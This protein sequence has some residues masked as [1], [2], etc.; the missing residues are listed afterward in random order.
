VPEKKGRSVRG[1]RGGEG[2]GAR[3][4]QWSKKADG[5]ALAIPRKERSAEGDK[6]SFIGKNARGGTKKKKSAE[7]S[8]TLLGGRMHMS[9]F[10]LGVMFMC[11]KR[12][13]ETQNVKKEAGV[14][15]KNLRKHNS[16][17]RIK[18]TRKKE[19]QKYKMV[20]K[21]PTFGVRSMRKRNAMVWSGKA[22]KRES[23]GGLQ[24][25]LPE[26]NSTGRQSGAKIG[27]GYRPVWRTE[28]LPREKKGGSNE[29]LA[30][31]W[32]GKGG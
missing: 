21:G 30:K 6:K 28:R 9:S 14:F 8:S 25:T 19:T 1:G 31:V 26:G 13:G 27:G 12:E 5:K 17:R 32:A 7:K 22:E 23:S 29:A 24:R 20:R 16:S 18:L 10:G 4:I 11:R 15:Q 3:F 2:S